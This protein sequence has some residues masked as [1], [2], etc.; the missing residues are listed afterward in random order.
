M[1]FIVLWWFIF[2]WF[3]D[4]YRFSYQ[5]Y[6]KNIWFHVKEYWMIYFFISL[7]SA[8]WSYMVKKLQFKY[9]SFN[10][11]RSINFTLLVISILFIFFKNI[12]WIIPIL[13]LS[14][15]FG[16]I[17]ILW[18]NYLIENSPKTHK[19]TILSIF[20]FAVSLWYFTFSAIAWLFI[21]LYNLETVYFYIPLIL[22]LIIL[23][24]YIYFR[25]KYY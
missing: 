8:L 2:A 4:I 25:K 5:E 11:L 3:W 6:L 22:G 21:D 24:D 17:M 18:N 19:S 12:Y 20:S 14:V 15:I 1:Y 9:S 10:I 16:F 13:I 23:I 7:F